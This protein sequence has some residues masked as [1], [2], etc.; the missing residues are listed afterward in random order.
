MVSVLNHCKTLL[1]SFFPYLL[2]LGSTQDRVHQYRLD[3][4]LILKLKGILI[5]LPKINL[6]L[7]TDKSKLLNF[8]NVQHQG[9]IGHDKF[10]VFQLQLKQESDIFLNFSAFVHHVSVKI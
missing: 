5:L 7:Y 1:F 6:N 2:F 10:L 9:T 3:E 4:Q 8:S